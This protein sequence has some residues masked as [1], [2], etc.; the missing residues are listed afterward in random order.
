MF[1]KGVLALRLYMTLLSTKVFGMQTSNWQMVKTWIKATSLGA[2][3]NPRNMR[4]VH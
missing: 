1:D 4:N 2:Y 3:S